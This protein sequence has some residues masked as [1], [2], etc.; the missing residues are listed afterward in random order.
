MPHDP[1]LT[2]CLEEY[3]KKQLVANYH[4]DTVKSFVELMGAAGIDSPGKPTRSHIYRRVF[5]NEVRTF[6]DI[7][8]SREPGCMLNHKI[9][10]KYKQD[11]EMGNTGSWN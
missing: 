6:E 3:D 8:P 5:M 9:P 11:F 10:E 4:E 2:V 1:A 7:F